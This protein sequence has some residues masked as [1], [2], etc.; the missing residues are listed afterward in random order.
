MGNLASELSDVHEGFRR[1][2]AEAFARWRDQVSDVIGRAQ[3]QGELAARA[4]P[5]RMAQFMVA[6]LEGAMLMSKVTKEIEVME[7][8]VAQLKE[9]LGLYRAPRPLSVHPSLAQ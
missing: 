8:C 5:A 9:H 4:E 2:L 6:A 1:R 3:A 7:E